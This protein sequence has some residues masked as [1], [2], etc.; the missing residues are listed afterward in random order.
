MIDAAFIKQC[1][2]PRLSVEI[3]QQFVQEIGVTDPLQ[4]TVKS[5]NRTFAVPKPKTVEEAKDLTIQYLG[6]AVVRVG[7]TRY[8]AG[9][10]IQNAD[11]LNMDLFEPCENLRMG[12]ALFSKVYRI[13]TKWY[14]NPRPEAFEDAMLSYASGYF[15]GQN[16]FKA[17]DPGSVA[18][19]KPTP[20]EQLSAA[21]LRI[22]GEDVPAQSSDPVSEVMAVAPGA[23]HTGSLE[24]Q[25]VSEP[26]FSNQDPN[27]APMRINLTGIK[28]HNVELGSTAK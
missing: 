21:Q 24:G 6:Q 1:A 12:T 2:D 10:G 15:E 26:P 18:V 7:L 17:E 3:V 16:V 5:G 25:G 23:D 20:V 8:P 22:R 14:G 27:R 28:V 9:Y 19:W 13:V 4:V 11:E